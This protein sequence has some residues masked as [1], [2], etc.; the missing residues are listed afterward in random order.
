MPLDS[1]VKVGQ[2]IL[3]IDPNNELAIGQLADAYLT[4]GDTTKAVEM[5]LKLYK[6][7]PTNVSQAQT[8]EPAAGN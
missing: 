2:E 7:N 6:L 8:Q 1:V 3:A 4:K 5:N